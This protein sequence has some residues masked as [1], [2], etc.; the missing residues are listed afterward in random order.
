M[1]VTEEALRVD[2][3]F[4]VAAPGDDRRNRV[5]GLAPERATGGDD[6]DAHDPVY[7]WR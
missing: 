4:A 6:G 2:D 7:G 3:E 1:T 5:S